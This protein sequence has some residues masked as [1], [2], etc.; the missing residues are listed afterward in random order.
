[1][2]V[3][4]FALALAVALMLPATTACAQ[5]NV[6][7]P[8][9]TAGCYVGAEITPAAGAKPYRKPAVPVTAIRLQRGYPQLALEEEQARPADGGRLINL[10]VIVTFADAGKQGGP[11]RYANGLYDT[12]RC[13]AGMCD[14]G[15]YR[16]ERRADDTVL[17]RMTG[18][19]NLSGGP[20]GAHA[21][22][23]LP[24]GRVYRLVAEPMDACR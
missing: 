8:P 15:N 23:R 22:R 24:D 19:L 12:L 7:F 10:R 3:Q 16:V 18:G 17:L 1:M 4:A 9:A 13:S 2:S 6:L 20:Q 14:A 5:P 11:K 21:S